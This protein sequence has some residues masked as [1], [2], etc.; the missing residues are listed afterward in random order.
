M[1]LGIILLA[2]VAVEQLA[3]SLLARRDM[4]SLLAGG[5]HEVA[6]GRYP[7]NVLLQAPRVWV[8]TTLGRRWTTRIIVLPGAPLVTTSP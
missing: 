5:A 4:A 1:T 7:L 2:C 6:P 3:E 8:L